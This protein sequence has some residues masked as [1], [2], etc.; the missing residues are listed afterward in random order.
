[1]N[2]EE[3]GRCEKR[4]GFDCVSEVDMEGGQRLSLFICRKPAL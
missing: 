3:V 4:V 2:K 1:M